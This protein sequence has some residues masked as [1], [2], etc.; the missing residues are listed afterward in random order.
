[1][2]RWMDI[3]DFGSLLQAS[4]P[5]SPLTPDTPIMAVVYRTAG[6]PPAAAP[7]LR[8]QKRYSSQGPF[9]S[10]STHAAPSHRLS[11]SELQ[12]IPPAARSTHGLCP[13]F[14]T[15]CIFSYLLV[16]PHSPS[17]APTLSP[18]IPGIR[19]RGE[20]SLP[21]LHP[22]SPSLTLDRRA[23]PGRQGHGRSYSYPFLQ[24]LKQ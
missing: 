16:P 19:Q 2:D 23:A 6:D 1:M 18:V 4:S 10:T 8:A 9:T 24:H 17:P 13:A 14:L 15:L 12:A 21:E 22:Q 5:T 3:V 20:C 11:C 7:A